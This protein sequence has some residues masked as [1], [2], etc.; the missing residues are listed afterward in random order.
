MSGF[1]FFLF[2]PFSFFFFRHYFRLFF[3]F[4]FFLTLFKIVR[5]SVSFET[6]CVSCCDLEGLEIDG[7]REIGKITRE[8]LKRW[9]G[10][11]YSKAQDGDGCG[12]L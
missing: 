9:R 4:Y 6:N 1:P 8:Q 3:S 12:F 7:G 2:F 10:V 11:G 5:F